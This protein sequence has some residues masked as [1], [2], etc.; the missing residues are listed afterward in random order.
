MSELRFTVDRTLGKLSKWLRILGFDTHFAALADP[1]SLLVH[2][3]DDRILLTRTRRMRASR[4]AKRLVVVEQDHVM[5]QLRELIQTLGIRP[6]DVSPFCRC[7]HCNDLIQPIEKHSVYEQVPDHVW[8]TQERF[9]QCPACQR[10]F[11]PGSH[12]VRT[13][14]MIDG[15]F[16]EKG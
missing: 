8:E 2:L 16:E 14:E 11:W 6:D 5:A 12:T 9:T 3:P 7:L 1:A 13:L 10:I 15:L 4:S